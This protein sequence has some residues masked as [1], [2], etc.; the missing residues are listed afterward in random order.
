MLREM[1][2][3]AERAIDHQVR[4]LENLD[5]KGAQTVTAAQAALA[6]AVALVAFV[7]G[8]A[9]GPVEP[10]TMVLFAAGAV[11][12]VV[13]L[14]AQMGSAR[15]RTVHDQVRVAPHHAWIEEKAKEQAWEL[16]RHLLS[17]LEGLARY[18][19]GNLALME[20][21]ARRRLHAQRALSMGLGLY[22][23]SLISL[24]WTLLI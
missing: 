6:G 4:A 11:A 23:A 22:G 16:E 9:P 5:G 13:A 21:A 2:R 24:V 1:V 15:G 7:I 17:V 18:A 8:Q 14:V 3:E 10:L 20:I 19:E 12:N